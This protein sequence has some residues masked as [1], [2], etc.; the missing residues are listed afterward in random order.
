MGKD[1]ITTA[2]EFFE[3]TI[4][5]LG[6]NQL[7]KLIYGELPVDEDSAERIRKSLQMYDKAKPLLDELGGFFESKTARPKKGKL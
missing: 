1:T 7:Y 6:E 4:K 3:E 2:K 5:I